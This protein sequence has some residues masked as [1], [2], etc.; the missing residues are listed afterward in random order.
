MNNFPD[1]VN[2]KPRQFNSW[3]YDLVECLA[4]HP[5]CH[6]SLRF[7]SAF[8]CRHPQRKE[9]IQKLNAVNNSE[10]KTDSDNQSE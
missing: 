6:A 10:I 5:T 3:D 2:C 7:G 9:I 8:L 1:I 4:E